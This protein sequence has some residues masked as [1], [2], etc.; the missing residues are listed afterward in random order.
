MDVEYKKINKKTGEV[1]ATEVINYR[2]LYRNASKAK[3]GQVMFINTTLYDKAY[4]WIT[5]GLGKKLPED[6]AKI[7]E[8]SAYAPLVTSTIVDTVHIPVEDIL[9]LKDQDSFFTTVA[10]IVKSAAEVKI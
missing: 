9:I 10:D 7:V 2:M 6:N 1:T 4:D 3:T 8:I 5:M